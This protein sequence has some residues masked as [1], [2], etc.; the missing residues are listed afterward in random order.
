MMRERRTNIEEVR[1]IA[2]GRKGENS[3]DENDW[4]EKEE[5]YNEDEWREKGRRILARW[6]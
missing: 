6:G 5:E 2:E 3:G 4:R 1:M